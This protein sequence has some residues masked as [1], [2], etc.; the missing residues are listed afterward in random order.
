M[1]TP[2]RKAPR[3]RRGASRPRPPDLW[4]PVPKASEPEP[5]AAAADVTA[6]LRSLP[7]PPLKGQGS[8]ARHYLA[9]VIERTARVATA[10]VA[11]AGLLAAPEED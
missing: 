7:D 2:R 1:N 3:R 11:T 6:L 10:L 9:A 4:S 8:V 5:I